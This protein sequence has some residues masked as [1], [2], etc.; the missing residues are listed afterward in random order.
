ML[1]GGIFGI[2][3]RTVV[4]EQQDWW[5]E[6]WRGLARIGRGAQLFLVRAP[7]SVGWK[8]RSD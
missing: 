2:G 8:Q 3:R 7:K 5:F 4:L 6:D 1:D